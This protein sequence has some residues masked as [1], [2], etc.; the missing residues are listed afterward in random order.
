MVQPSAPHP[1][2]DTPLAPLTHPPTHPNPPPSPTFCDG[3]Q[4][5]DVVRHSP[6]RHWRHQG[7]RQRAPQ[8]LRAQQAVHQLAHLQTGVWRS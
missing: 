4:Y 6:P 2:R 1:N 7:F 8:A 3:A 5:T